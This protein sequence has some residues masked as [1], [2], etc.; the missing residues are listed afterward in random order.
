MKRKVDLKANAK[1]SS[2][3]DSGVP[4]VWHVG[5]LPWVSLQGGRHSTGL[6]L[7]YATRLTQCSTTGVTKAVVC[8]ILS[9]G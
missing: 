8:A 9:V 2:I 1:I 4:R 6:F 7:T 3:F 5:Q